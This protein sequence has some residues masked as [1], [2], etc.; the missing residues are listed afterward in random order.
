M[1]C[2]SD[3]W[4]KKVAASGLPVWLFRTETL[5]AKGGGEMATEK[6]DLDRIDMLN[7]KELREE[8][9]AAIAEVEL[10]RVETQN[11]RDAVRLAVYSNLKLV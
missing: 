7:E 2:G 8:L 4:I 10:L 3:S 1:V 11:L 5:T 6:N 9:R